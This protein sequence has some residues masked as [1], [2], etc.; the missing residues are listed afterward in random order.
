MIEVRNLEYYYKTFTKES[1]LL[2]SIEDFFRR[3]HEMIHVLKN[4]DLTIDEG[5][6]IGLIG[7]NGAGKTTFIKTLIGI[8]EPHSGTIRVNGFTPFKKEK[9]FLKDIG[10]VIGQ[11]SQL[12][13]D[14]PAIETLDMLKI[15]YEVEDRIYKERLSEMLDVLQLNHKLKTPVRKLSLGERIKFEIIASLLHNPKVLFLDEPTIGL[16]LTSQI[17]IHKFLKKQNEKYKTTILLTSHYVKDIEALCDRV[18]IIIKGEKKEDT[19]IGKL[20]EKYSHEKEFIVVKLREA[21][22]QEELLGWGGLPLEDGSFQFTEETYER[23]KEQVSIH[24]IESVQRNKKSFA[25]V[26]FEIY[27]G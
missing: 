16:D 25:D 3:K 15:I 4:F 6:I 27:E 10:V 22:P 12:I 17:N 11:K 24:K 13:W 26:I 19:T 5:E 1:G 20:I 14:L 9:A 2:G 21:L 18:L 7:P 23:F 8:L